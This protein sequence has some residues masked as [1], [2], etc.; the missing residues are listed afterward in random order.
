MNI[1]DQDNH[2][3][4]HRYRSGP[5][6]GDYLRRRRQELGLSLR[7]V[8]EQTNGAIGDAGLSRLETGF[9]YPNLTTLEA[10]AGPLQLL[11]IIGPDTTSITAIAQE[12]A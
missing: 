6:L 1:L 7:D 10:L 9:R 12:P 3:R 11:I 8:A 5:W 2:D 4:V